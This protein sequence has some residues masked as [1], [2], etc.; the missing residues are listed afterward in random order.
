MTRILAAV[1]MLLVAA[2]AL[3]GCAKPTET[4]APAVEASGSLPE[5]IHDER[6]I[7][8][9]T[10]IG[11]QGCHPAHVC[12]GFPF[13][14]TVDAR[15][16]AT[17]SWGRT[18]NYLGLTLLQDGAEIMTVDANDPPAWPNIM[19]GMTLPPGEYVLFVD[20][21]LAAADRWVLDVVFTE[22]AFVET[23]G[24]APLRPA[25]SH[26]AG[27]HRIDATAAP[28]IPCFYAL[29]GETVEPTIGVD[30]KTGTVFF[31]PVWD[32]C[33]LCSDP[34]LA[35]S[36]D[37]GATWELV[38]PTLGGQTTHPVTLDPYLYLDPA[39]GRV[40]VDDL[41]Q[42]CSVISWTDDLG[43][44]WDHTPVG[45]CMEADHQTLFAGP[46][47]ISPTLAYPNVVYRC[48]AN[49]VATHS[50]STTTTCQRSIDGG[51]SW[52]P[53]GAPAFGPR[54]DG[55]S[56]YGLPA[57]CT[58]LVGHGAVG[59]DGTVY[60]PKG[61]CGEPWLAISRDEG[62]TW[63]RTKVA[64]LGFLADEYGN[65]AHDAGV[66]I[67]AAGTIYYG[68]VAKDRMPY[69]AVSRDGGATFE[70]PRMVAPPGVNE[71][72][73][74]ELIAGGAG[75]FAF[76][77]LGTTNS[78]GNFTDQGCFGLQ[79]TCVEPEAYRN[80]TWNAYV[81][82]SLDADTPAPTYWTVTINDPQDPI[83]RGHCNAVR[84][85]AG[86]DFFDIRIGP[87]GSAWVALGDSCTAQCP[88]GNL[89]IVG[90][91]RADLG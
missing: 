44:T 38:S 4:A 63:T 45:G 66:G 85:G 35:R 56:S 72:S 23:P 86:H 31:Y 21:W 78:P 64:D 9:S 87:D 91:V 59:P 3:A 15:I 89:A 11:N 5:P 71:A 49:T 43:A 8:A 69:V 77:Y 22:P 58:G 19:L 25:V 65:Q 26:A 37:D 88:G 70:P 40:F 55:T 90:R 18:G 42:F 46:P 2:A 39:T 12:A 84:C 75:K 76:L 27:A 33:A 80:T 10:S 16:E 67:D 13:T 74:P 1:G 17:L 82:V 47:V 81:T 41:V 53:P 34:Q 14:L 28:P 60:L 50:S 36:Q 30:P 54:P 83:L 24:C 68:W 6:D 61:W 29:P 7:V 48:A 62:L 20:A 79:I 51:R 32:D 73:K 52:L 57:T